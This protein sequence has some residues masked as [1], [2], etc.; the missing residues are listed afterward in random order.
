MSPVVVVCPRLRVGVVAALFL[1]STSAC[2]E[3]HPTAQTAAPPR[4]DVDTAYTPPSGRTIAVRKGEDFQAALNAAKPGDVLVLEAGAVFTGPF[5]LPAKPGS[6][7]IIVRSS[8]RESRVAPRL[9][10]VPTSGLP[11]PGGRVDPSYAPFMPQL[12]AAPGPVISAE[13]GAHHYRFI[14]IE[15]RPG[16]AGSASNRRI[17]R[18]LWRVFLGQDAAAQDSFSGQ[19]LVLLGASETSLERLPQHIIFDRCYLHGDP[20]GGARRGIAM[21]SRYTAVIDSYLADFKEVGADSQAIAGWNGPGPF[22]IANNYLEA[23]GENVMFGG[24]DPAIANL[25]PADIEIRGNHFAKPLSW[26]IGDPGYAGTPW[27]VKNLFE[28]KNARRVLIDG[29]LF[30]YNWPHA[31]NGFAILFTV[32]NQDGAAPWSVVEDVSF[33]NNIVRHVGSGVNILGRDDIHPSQQTRRISIKNNLFYDV[34]GIWGRGQLFQ[35]LDGTAQVTIDHNTALQTDSVVLGGDGGAHSGFVFSNN[36][37]PHNAFGIIGSGFG[38]GLPTLERY[39]PGAIV[40]RNVLIGGVPGQYPPDNFFPAALDDV[41]FIDRAAEDYRL[42]ASSPYAHAATGG[43][44][45]GVDFNVFCA[46]VPTSGPPAISILPC[47]VPGT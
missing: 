7:W 43:D 42:Q 32:R 12:V 29:N 34:G 37:A 39:F 19:T 22:K 46:A 2:A 3:S 10:S 26:R 31:Q 33:T 21:N 14:G 27:T 6:E 8:A 45:V 36:I 24:A 25:V 13:P 4:P 41:G 9:R 15:I 20:I 38:I 40:R 35:L 17:L 5:T 16:R 11:P 18:S 44:A 23:A 28:L 30:E 47:T 1:L